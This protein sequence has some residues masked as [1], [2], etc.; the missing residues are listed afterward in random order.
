MG[1]LCRLW[2]MAQLKQTPEG[3]ERISRQ[4]CRELSD[5]TAENTAGRPCIK[6][7]NW[8]AF[9]KQGCRYFCQMFCA[10]TEAWGCIKRRREKAYPGMDS[11][12]PGE[13]NTAWNLASSLQAQALL[14]PQ[15]WRGAGM[16]IS[17]TKHTEE[18]EK[19][20]VQQGGCVPTHHLGK[21]GDMEQI[22]WRLSKAVFWRIPM[23]IHSTGIYQ[24][25]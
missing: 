18:T 23:K 14:V 1:W 21:P 9:H 17:L 12:Y 6:S 4:G 25:D 13:I 5:A 16:L 2:I 10:C 8:V 19:I 3:A 20:T 22:T 11:S 24:A 15:G 7:G